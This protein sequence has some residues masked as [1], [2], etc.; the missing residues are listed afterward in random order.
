MQI[1]GIISLAARPAPGH[2][3][4]SPAKPSPFRLGYLISGLGSQATQP[5]QTSSQQHQC[6]I[7]VHSEPI[8][9]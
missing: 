7:V 3:P 6:T 9:A 8:L 1:S 5:M 4:L 2:R